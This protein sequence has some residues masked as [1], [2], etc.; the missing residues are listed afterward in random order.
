MMPLIGYDI[1][2][3][4]YSQHSYLTTDDGRDAFICF[5]TASSQFDTV[6]AAKLNRDDKVTPFERRPL[7]E[8]NFRLAAQEAANI[9]IVD[10]LNVEL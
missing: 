9:V 1:R 10:G 4:D 8:V 3:G 2:V 7:S 6:L 5:E